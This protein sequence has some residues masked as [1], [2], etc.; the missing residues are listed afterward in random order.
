MRELVVG[1]E[2][3]V[4][5]VNLPPTLAHDPLSSRA[6]L[7]RGES[8][9]RAAEGE[10]GQPGHD[11]DIDGLAC[12]GLRQVE[13][14]LL[15]HV[16]CENTI[17]RGPDGE[18][19]DNRRVSVRELRERI[20]VAVLEPALIERAVVQPVHPYLFRGGDPHP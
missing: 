9:A 19:I 8:V 10:A 18:V 6:A 16:L 11:S 14:R 15:D 7:L 12:S 4:W 1:G 20:R 3:F 17:P 2:L 5:H 13:E